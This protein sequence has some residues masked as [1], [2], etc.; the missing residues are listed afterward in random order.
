MGAVPALALA[1]PASSSL[2]AE[3]APASFV[4]SN[5]LQVTSVQRLDQRL[6]ELTVTTSAL[7]GPA[8][9]RILLPAKYEDQAKRHYPVLYLFHGTS[10]GAADW[11]VK[12]EA[13]QT[14]EGLPL[15]VVMPDI[16]LNDDGGGYCT[17]WVSGT[18]SWERFHI[19]QLIPW[20]DANL[21][22]RP[23]RKGRAI[24]GLSQGGFCSLS[25]AARHP[26]LFQTALAYSGVPDIAYNASDKEGMTA[27]ATATETG[28]DG[29]PPN[30]M[31]GSRADNEIN[32]ANH[33]PTTLANNLRATPYTSTSAMA[34]PDRWKNRPKLEGRPWR[35][36][37]M[38]TTFTSTTARPNSGSSRASM[39][40]TGR[41]HTPG[42]TGPVT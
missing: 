12:G 15:I 10:G 35:R 13:E 38:K 41:A 18:Y 24:A 2:A 31:F 42:L 29:E 26:D 34:N 27:I 5:G 40:I 32:W 8:K 25:Y 22:T 39:T 4:S 28:L 16:A 7:P 6:Y 30:S 14:T 1:L 23:T 11:T 37:C 36:S 9:V 21:R 33:D 17:N 20:V 19:D 3:K